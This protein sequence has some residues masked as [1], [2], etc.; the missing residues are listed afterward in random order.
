MDVLTLYTQAQLSLEK[1][2]KKCVWKVLNLC[3]SN[4]MVCDIRDRQANKNVQDMNHKWSSVD[5][6]Q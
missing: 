3:I 5:I 1:E 2:T 4:H 6:M